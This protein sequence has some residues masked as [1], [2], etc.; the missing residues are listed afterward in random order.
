LPKSEEGEA[1]A[2]KILIPPVNLNA[3]ASP[4]QLK[5][6]YVGNWRLM[7]ARALAPSEAVL[8]PEEFVS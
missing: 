1:F 2:D 6:D 7:A 5:I 8:L 4:L 3:N